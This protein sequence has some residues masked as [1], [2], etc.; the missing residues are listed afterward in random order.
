MLNCE[1]NDIGTCFQFTHIIS[2]NCS[3]LLDGHS[4]CTIVDS[5]LGE[6][7][8]AGSFLGPQKGTV[9]DT[10]GKRKAGA[11][12]QRKKRNVEGLML[13][14][15]QRQENRFRRTFQSTMSEMARRRK[16]EAINHALCDL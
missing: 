6:I 5:L 1:E 15:A 13:I 2:G 7:S 16:T 9:S 4:L 11:G 8:D 3:A 10:G 14:L 12:S